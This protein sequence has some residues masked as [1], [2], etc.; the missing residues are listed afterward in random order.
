MSI[1]VVVRLSV[2]ALC[3]LLCLFFHPFFV[4]M[5]FSISFLHQ[6]TGLT[7][8]DYRGRAYALPEYYHPTAWVGRHAVEWLDNY[9]SAQPFMLKVRFDGRCELYEHW[10][11]LPCSYPATAVWFTSHLHT[12]TTW[13]ANCSQGE[14][15]KPETCYVKNR[16]ISFTVI[17]TRGTVMM[18]YW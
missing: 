7:F 13:L 12:V 2:C 8:N 1:D 17:I 9:N 10:Y 18:I 11:W 3:C 15:W 5:T 4:D 6:V 14:C 16:V